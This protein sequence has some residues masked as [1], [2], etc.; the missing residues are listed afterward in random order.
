MDDMWFRTRII[1][2]EI[3][4]EDDIATI[5]QCLKTLT[6]VQGL[7]VHLSKQAIS[8]RYDMS[9]INYPDL[10]KVLEK[11]GFVYKNNFLN[12]LKKSW[13]TFVDKTAHDNS[14]QQPKA[15]CNRPPHVHKTK[16]D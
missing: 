3:I 7:V 14:Q 15:C 1:Y 10:V 4:E 16:G 13:I 11:S 8:I 12:K 9:V 5:Q 6:G 2:L